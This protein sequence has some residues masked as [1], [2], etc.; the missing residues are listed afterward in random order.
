MGV[1]G[2]VM[3]ESPIL[4]T[5]EL[6][7]VTWRLGVTSDTGSS[8]KAIPCCTPLTKLATYIDTNIALHSIA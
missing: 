2:V 5:R 3:E 4:D 8:P 1:E 6:E 7:T